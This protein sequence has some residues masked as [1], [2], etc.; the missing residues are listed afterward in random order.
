MLSVLKRAHELMSSEQG[1]S[2]SYK[3]LL[4]KCID[5]SPYRDKVYV[6]VE[7]DF[8]RG[9][10][11]EEHWLMSASDYTKLYN[12]YRSGT[13]L[14]EFGEINGKHSNVCLKWEECITE[15][16]KDAHHIYERLMAVNADEHGAD[17]HLDL[18]DDGEEGASELPSDADGEVCAKKPRSEPEAPPIISPVQATQDSV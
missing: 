12:Q 8:C 3:E 9:G 16:I 13:K 4:D 14:F 17:D 2:L 15:V 1:Q 11:H 10:S 18:W 5:A 7:V 6:H